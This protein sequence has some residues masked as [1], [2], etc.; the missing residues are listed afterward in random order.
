M[1]NLINKLINFFGIELIREQ[2]LHQL[3]SLEKSLQDLFTLLENNNTFKGKSKSQ[4]Y[5]DFFV[6]MQLNFKEHGFL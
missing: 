1:K 2:R 5:Q 3:V 6:L 4:L